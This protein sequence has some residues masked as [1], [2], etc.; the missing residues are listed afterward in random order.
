MLASSLPSRERGRPKGQ[1]ANYSKLQSYEKVKFENDSPN[2]YND[3][4]PDNSGQPMEQREQ[5]DAC[6]SY[7]ESRQRSS[8]AQD[9]GCRWTSNRPE[10]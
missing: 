5:S 6:I 3:D 8:S 2:G 10:W 9:S 7:V 4:E 1:L